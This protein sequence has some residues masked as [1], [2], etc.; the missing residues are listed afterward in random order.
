MNYFKCREFDCQMITCFILT[1]EIQ[2]IMA[3]H[4]VYI[5]IFQETKSRLTYC[6]GTSSNLVIT[7][8]DN[9][10]MHLHDEPYC[11]WD[12]Q[13]WNG[14]VYLF[15]CWNVLPKEKAPAWFECS[16]QKRSPCRKLRKVSPIMQPNTG[17]TILPGSG[18]SEM[19][20]DHRSMS[21]GDA[22]ISLSKLLAV[23][24]DFS[25]FFVIFR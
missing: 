21:S 11:C 25:W 24:W 9:F 1:L 8:H 14:A 20:A 10:T 13:D 23:I 6:C 12:W 16:Y 4:F 5:F 15:I 19:P 2:I 17:P 18:R 3:F 22:Y 7:V